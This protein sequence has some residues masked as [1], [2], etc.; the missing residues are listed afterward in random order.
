MEALDS[1]RAFLAP[2]GYKICGGLEEIRFCKAKYLSGFWA[3]T[4]SAWPAEFLISEQRVELQI[5]PPSRQITA[6]E[7]KYWEQELDRLVA[8]LQ[9]KPM[10]A[11]SRKELVTPSMQQNLIA[12]VAVIVVIGLGTYFFGPKIGAVL[13]VLVLGMLYA[14]S[15]RLTA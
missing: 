10:A 6:S 9:G 15:R 14:V 12:L 3:I 2:R 5:R 4:P 1:A 7:Q 11:V 8:H 13:L